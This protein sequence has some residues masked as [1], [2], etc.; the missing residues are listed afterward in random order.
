M[1]IVDIC[2]VF[3]CVTGLFSLHVVRPS[4]LGQHS[5]QQGGVFL[6][7]FTTILSCVL[8]GAGSTPGS[9]RCSQSSRVGLVGSGNER[10][11]YAAVEWVSRAMLQFSLHTDF[12]FISCVCAFFVSCINELKEASCSPA[13]FGF[14]FNVFSCLPFR[15]HRLLDLRNNVRTTTTTTTTTT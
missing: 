10:K 11:L 14:F 13:E 5:R 3:F 6:S 1:A 9:H 7:G 2:N 8:Y 15:D 4:S 12:D